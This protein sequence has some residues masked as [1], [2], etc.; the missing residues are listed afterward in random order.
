MILGILVVIVIIIFILMLF[1]TQ[2]V[3]LSL[4]M[5]KHFHQKAS[6]RSKL[7]VALPGRSGGR[8]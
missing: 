4:R 7:S 8:R 1:D 2:P 6:A 5:P 3:A